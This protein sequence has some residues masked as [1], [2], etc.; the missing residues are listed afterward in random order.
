MGSCDVVAKGIGFHA[1]GYSA[2]SLGASV[3]ICILTR[4][5]AYKRFYALMVLISVYDFHAF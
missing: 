3:L 1:M 4:I 2:C 5:M